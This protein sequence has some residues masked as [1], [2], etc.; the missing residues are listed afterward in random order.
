MTAIPIQQDAPQIIRDRSTCAIQFNVMP[1]LPVEETFHVKEYRVSDR[2]VEAQFDRSYRSA[3]A[4]SPDHLVFLTALTHMQKLTY[5]AVCRELGYEY[6]PD[7]PEHLKI[8][9]TKLDIRIPKLYSRSKDVVQSFTLFELK[10]FNETTYRA[11]GESR[12][13]DALCIKASAPVVIV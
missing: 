3:M 1:G 8:W 5:L 6:D 4:S 7:G 12:V 9:P 13:D 11:V 10:K 2:Y